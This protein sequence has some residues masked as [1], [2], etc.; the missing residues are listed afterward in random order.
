MFLPG[1]NCPNGYKSVSQI[2]DGRTCQGFPTPASNSFADSTCIVDDDK[3]RDK[4]TPSTPTDINR[5]ISEN[6]YVRLNYKVTDMFM[7]HIFAGWTNLFGLQSPWMVMD[8]G[9]TMMVIQ[10][11]ILQL[12]LTWEDQ[13]PLDG[14]PVQMSWMSMALRLVVWQFYL[15][16]CWMPALMMNVMN[17][18][19]K[20]VNINVGKLCSSLLH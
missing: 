19:P 4:W 6:G 20:L 18:T 13:Q 3:L 11:S 15:L 2:S 12:W 7:D 16:E 5:F 9:F 17:P 14:H 10:K 1:L 8:N